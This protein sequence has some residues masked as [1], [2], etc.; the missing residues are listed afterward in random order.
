MSFL[1]SWLARKPGL[2]KINPLPQ[3]SQNSGIDDS[4]KGFGDIGDIGVKES[5]Q[6]K[7]GDGRGEAAL[8]GQDGGL[9]LEIDMETGQAWYEPLNGDG[10]DPGKRIYVTSEQGHNR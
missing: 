9:H 1:D 2:I 6:P 8:L 10:K 3:N 7:P 4:E 5:S